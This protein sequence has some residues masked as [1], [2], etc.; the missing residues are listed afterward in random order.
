MTETSP[1]PPAGPPQA[2]R[3]MPFVDYLVLEP[4]PH[5]IAHEC[6]DCAARYF[7]RRDACANCFGV[8][9]H[10]V[11]VADT[12]RVVSFTIVHQARPGVKAPFVGAIVDC[13]GTWVRA[14]L[15]DVEPDPAVIRLDMPVQLTTYS[16]GIDSQG[17]EAVGYAYRPLG[18]DT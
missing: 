12:G 5:L 7:D 13:E 15:R 1:L 18:S 2:T 3:R 17:T 14:N 8:D 6:V 9:F 16:L 10:D 4:T 11:T